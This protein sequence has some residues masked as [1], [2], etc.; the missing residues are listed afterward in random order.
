VAAPEAEGEHVWTLQ[1]TV[2]EG[3]H[4]PATASV[5]VIAVRP[6]EHRVTLAVIDKSSGAPLGDVELRMGVYRATA[7]EAGIAH[8]EVPGGIY[9]VAAWKLGHEMLSRSVHVATD[10]SIQ[11]ELAATAEPETPY[12]M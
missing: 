1:A 2:P 11:L 3:S 6:P 12:W 7:N 8:L 5:R 4:A 9:D 10:V